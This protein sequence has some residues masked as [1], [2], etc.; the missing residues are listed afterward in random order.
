MRRILYLGLG[1][2]A[3]VIDRIATFGCRLMYMVCLTP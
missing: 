2:D 3:G 1:T